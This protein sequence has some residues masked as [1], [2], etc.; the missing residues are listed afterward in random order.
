[1]RTTTTLL[2]RTAVA[3]S[4]AVMA[5]L[6]ISIPAS[7]DAPGAL[8]QVVDIEFP[9]RIEKYRYT[10][11]GR[12]ASAADDRNG[13]AK[14]RVVERSG[15][16]CENYITIDERGRLYDL[17]GKWINFTD[18]SGKTWRSVQP[19]E[20]LV[21]GEGTI[22]GAPGGDII[23]VEWDPYSGDHL[24]SYKYDGKTETWEFLE[25]PLHTPFYDRPW[26]S[27]VPGPFEVL[28]EKVPYVVFVDGFPHRGPLLYSTDGLTYA[29]ISHPLVDHNFAGETKGWLETK[30]TKDLDWME[31]NT[32]SPITPLGG[33]RAL[34]L[35]GPFVP[36]YSMF[37]PKSQQWTQHTFPGGSGFKGRILVDSEGRV[38]N[39]V[40]QGGFFDYRISR[41][42]GKSWESTRITLPKG[43][44]T[45]AGL[46]VDFRV[47]A[48]VGTAAVAMHA[49]DGN[50]NTDVDLVYTLDISRDKARTMRL[51]EVGKGDI[52]AS[53]GVGQD[54]RFDFETVAIFPDGRI[55]VSFLDST[56]GPV[57]HL[58]EPIDPDRLGPALAIE[59]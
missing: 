52:D 19:L 7:G 17:G 58:Q 29:Q 57:F 45:S 40:P 23:G 36:D 35:P 32:N 20:P 47:N 33:G 46:E 9:Q 39:F 37:D 8:A 13:V 53:S 15:N 1:M 30:A 22:A 16:C 54:I 44:T 12:S 25:A 38:H 50:K 28:G 11:F 14:F 4:V 3:A 55:A 49:R 31:P 34:A 51:Y 24:L 41:N 59:L 6:A 21:N 56:T 18:D 2:T 10:D 5:A 48:E 42:G 43:I 26:L 27:V